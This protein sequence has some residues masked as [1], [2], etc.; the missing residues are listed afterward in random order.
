MF[1]C[2]HYAPP[3]KYLLETNIEKIAIEDKPQKAVAWWT[4]AG[5]PGMPNSQLEEFSE[6]AQEIRSYERIITR[7]IKLAESPIKTKEQYTYNN[8]FSLP[9]L[10]GK[11]IVLQNSNVGTW[12]HNSRY[13]FKAT[14]QIYIDDEGNLVGY[15]PYKEPL[16]VHFSFSDTNLDMQTGVYDIKSG[17]ELLK[18]AGEYKVAILPGSGKLIFIGSSEDADILHQMMTVEH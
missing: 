5:R 7:M 6:A 11:V 4:L 16:D 17:K 2:W 10:K 13:S 14:D 15:I 12:P 9:E 8:A 3:T 18:E 1:L